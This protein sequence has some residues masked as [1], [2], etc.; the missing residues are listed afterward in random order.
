[1]ATI[2]NVILNWVKCVK[3][4]TV[5]ITLSNNVSDILIVTRE[6]Y[7]EL[8]I[9][10]K[11]EEDIYILF[12]KNG[13]GQMSLELTAVKDFSALTANIVKEEN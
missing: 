3:N 7:D 5:D 13:L 4:E 6:I 11:S 1:M 10:G 2:I 8:K 12:K 9:Q